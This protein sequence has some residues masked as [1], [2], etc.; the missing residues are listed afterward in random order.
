MKTK[1]LVLG[2][3]PRIMASTNKAMGEA[4]IRYNEKMRSINTEIIFLKGQLALHQN[5][6]S[7][8]PKNYGYVGDLGK[9][10]SLLKEINQT[11]GNG[12]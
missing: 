9:I 3:N 11:F 2:K 10:E 1:K 7:K 12:K 6:F 4:E 8:E 5:N